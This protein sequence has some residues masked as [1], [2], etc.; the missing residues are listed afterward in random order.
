M[1]TALHTE[2][3]FGLTS[4]YSQDGVLRLDLPSYMKQ[5]KKKY[6]AREWTSVTKDSDP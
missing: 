2:Q 5:P 1:M 3:N 6:E 4:T